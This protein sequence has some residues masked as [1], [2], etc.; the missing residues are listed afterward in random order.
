MDYLREILAMAEV[1]KVIHENSMRL[2]CSEA[3]DYSTKPFSYN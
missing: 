1:S 3:Y 2:L